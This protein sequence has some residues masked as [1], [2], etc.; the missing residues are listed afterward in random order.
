MDEDLFRV[1]TR[2]HCRQ[3]CSSLYV[4]LVFGVEYL[5]FEYSVSRSCH[6]EFYFIFIIRY[7]YIYSS[8]YRSESPHFCYTLFIVFL[9]VFFSS[10]LSIGAGLL[11]VGSQDQRLACVDVL[12]SGLIWP[13]LVPWYWSS[14]STASKCDQLEPERFG[15][16]KQTCCLDFCRLS[17]WYSD[18]GFLLFPT[19]GVTPL[20][21]VS[22]AYETSKTFISSLTPP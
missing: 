7:I 20:S 10:S 1:T 15:Q 19:S 2:T 13:Q 14:P 17:A 11:Y 22:A 16:I 21:V 9:A 5:L 3:I 18:G 12:T 8:S 4:Q 6:F